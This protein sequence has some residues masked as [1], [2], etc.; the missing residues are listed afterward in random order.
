ML[1]VT[2]PTLINAWTALTTDVH[3]TCLPN[4]SCSES[5]LRCDGYIPFVIPGSFPELVL[6]NIDPEEFQ[7]QRFCHLHSSWNT[8]M[9]LDF[10]SVKASR[11]INLPNGVFDCLGNLTAFRLRSEWLKHFANFTYTGLSNVTLLDLSGCQMMNW[12]DL[13]DVLSFGQNFPKLDHLILS[14]A[15]NYRAVYLNMDDAFIN[16]L[17]MR[18][19]AYIDLS[20]TN[21]EFNFT[22]SQNLCKTLR[23]LSYAGAAVQHTKLFEKGNTCGSLKILD[24]SDAY[25]L[26]LMF[27]HNPCINDTLGLIFLARF[28][29]A[30]E[31]IVLNRIIMPSTKFV[32][33]NCKLDLFVGSLVT[34]IH[35]SQNYL[36]NFELQL[37]NDQ[38]EFLNISHGN[39]ENIH[40][41]AFKGLGYL[42]ELDLSFNKLSKMSFFDKHF[43]GLFKYNLYLE[44]VRLNGN[45]LGYIP[46]ETFVSNLYLE[47]LDLS[48][49]LLTQVT[50]EVAHLLQLKL[51]DLRFNNIEALDV[52]SRESL[53]AVYTNQ[54]NANKTE[55]VQVLLHGNPFTCQCRHLSFLQWLVNAPMFS[56]TR[57]EYKCKL[58]G[59]N[60]TVANDAISAATG[61]C[62][63]AR[64]KRLRIVLLSM[65]L[66]ICALVI[67]LILLLLYKQHKKKLLKQRF[68]NGIRRLREDVNRFPVFLSYSSDDCDFVRRHMLQQLQVH[69]FF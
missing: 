26:K 6:S 62:K 50:F 23:Y 63:R 59:H 36:P 4:C 14:G 43:S 41:K 33:R 40:P 8:L 60:F 44:N 5:V 13:Y 47:N 29:G 64:L 54:M 3:G 27:Q 39:I 24:M 45:E 31:V 55:T 20:Y 61:D 34:H 48:Y 69:C 1:F 22:K 18:P 7:P 28:Y 17:S 25:E 11:N 57:H 30:L 67:C 58:D 68:A 32:P 65:V 49:N 53:N 35:F 66:P 52:V 15:G 9:E 12:N 38:I 10:I 56:T 51:L 37:I 42:N 16:V 21:F 2:V 46:E 19:L